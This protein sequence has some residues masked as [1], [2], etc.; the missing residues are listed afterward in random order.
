MRLAG[1]LTSETLI[2]VTVTSTYDGIRRRGTV[3]I[4]AGATLVASTE[5]GY[6]LLGRLYSVSD[7]VCSA[8]Y[9]YLTNSPWIGTV[10]FANNGQTVM[11]TSRQYDS[12]NRL[13]QIESSTNASTVSSHTYDYN[14]AGQRTRATA[15]PDNT[16]WHYTYDALGQ[17]TSG[18]KR[19]GGA[20]PV[21]GQQFY[22]AFDTIGNR[23]W[24]QAGG[25][26]YGNGLRTAYYTNNA[27]N[28]ITARQVPGAVDILGIA[29]HNATVTVNGQSP[30][31]FGEY[32]RKE[33]SFANTA[34]ALYPA[35]TNVASYDGTTDTE[36]GR[37]FLPKTPETFLY[38]LDG[39]LTN[40]GR[41]TYTWDAENRLTRMVSRSDTPSESWQWLEFR[42]D[43][44]GRR[45]SKT[46]SNWVTGHWS[47]ITDHRFVY[48]GWNLIAVLTSDLTPLA[49][50]TWGTDASGTPQG[51]GGVGG[52]LSMTLHTGPNAGT[53]FPSY[54][55]NWNVVALVNAA[56]AEV[57]AQ[58]DYGPF[59]ELIRATGPVGR[60]NPF[61][62]A[63]KCYDWET[64]LYYYGYRYY[65]PS[66]GRWL[67]RDPVDESGGNNVYGY[68][69][70]C[71]AHKVDI[72]G[73]S[74]FDV[75]T[76][77]LPVEHTD[78]S[79]A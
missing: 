16:R 26:Q 24:T 3:A 37:L 79:L 55:G 46:V 29:R 62:A 64:A 72:L 27:L 49:T 43:W 73:L 68:V 52:L 74:G 45:L 35:V 23:L 78:Q 34:A 75:T 38:D 61:L 32:Y 50:F 4:Y 40:D 70:N 65:S 69:D 13:R 63:T 47:L 59:H 33:L 36:T 2:G 8:T 58:Y 71:A 15:A 25:D 56:T 17:V 19:W 14:L 11:T 21:A 30:Y 9:G 1:D 6:D 48:D 42:Y 5:Y 77:A 12:A 67:S 22:Y 18:V 28:Q 51:A 41:W 31:R 53:Y 7:G 39:N 44:Q 76:C 10:T 60:E 20:T 54:D 66:T 57:A